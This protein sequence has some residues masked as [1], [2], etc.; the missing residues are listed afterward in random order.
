MDKHAVGSNCSYQ[1]IKGKVKLQYQNKD[2]RS[3]AKSYGL[4][5]RIAG[6]F[7]VKGRFVVI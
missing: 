2:L 6:L 4:E 3:A 5:C 7:T 1:G